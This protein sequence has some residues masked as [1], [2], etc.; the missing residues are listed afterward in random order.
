MRKIIYSI[1][2]V[3]LL[4]AGCSEAEMIRYE[5]NGRLNVYGWYDRQFVGSDMGEDDAETSRRYSV[6]FGHVDGNVDTL[7]VGVRIMGV[8]SDYDRRV[9][10]K[11]VPAEGSET[12]DISEAPELEYIVPA[13]ASKAVLKYLIH[14]TPSGKELMGWWMP[15]FENSDFEPGAEGKDTFRVSARNYNLTLASL[16][17]TEAQ[18]NMF[19]GFGLLFGFSHTKAQFIIDF[20][21]T[22]F[23]RWLVW[24]WGPLS[25]CF[26]LQAALDEYRRDPNNPP[27]YDETKFPAL[28]WIYFTPAGMY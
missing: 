12:I 15:D 19:T 23:V 17:V 13:G 8:P 24:E 18:W 4:F 20:G 28:E 10:F 26:A 11:F 14:E 16:G 22:D 21:I 3:A 6:D 9:S 1:L 25:D 27:L 5:T 2:A 7:F